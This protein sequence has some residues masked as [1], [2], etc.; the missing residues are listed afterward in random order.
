MQIIQKVKYFFL[1]H[2]TSGCNCWENLTHLIWLVY[3]YIYLYHTKTA[4]LVDTGAVLYIFLSSEVTN[5][6]CRFYC[7][8]MNYTF[9]ALT[10]G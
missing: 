8:V 1:V 7:K 5:K 3:K 2:C 6:K 4:F 9:P 10:A